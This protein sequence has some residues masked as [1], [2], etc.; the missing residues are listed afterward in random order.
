MKTISI[1]QMI[2]NSGINNYD[3][4]KF[5]VQKVENK[6]DVS[7]QAVNIDGEWFIP[8]SLILSNPQQTIHDC[9]RFFPTTNILIPS[10]KPQEPQNG[11]SK[12][13]K[14]HAQQQINRFKW[15][16]QPS[17]IFA[18]VATLTGVASVKPRT[19][20]KIFPRRYKLNAVMLGSHLQKYKLKIVKDYGLN[21]QEEIQ[22]FM[23]PNEF[24]QM[25]LLNIAEKWK[26][27][28]F[29]GFNES[30]INTLLNF[31]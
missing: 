1:N 23:V 16:E 31:D 27:T 25:P 20:E 10:Y 8:M 22:N 12:Q 9:E 13:H 7:S 6:T 15:S 14:H 24:N 26:D 11:D 17:L 19:I 28:T 29:V 18:Y 2:P 30:E 21:G 4:T 5:A 3:L